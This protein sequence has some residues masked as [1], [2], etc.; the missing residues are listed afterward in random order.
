MNNVL[1]NLENYNK[2]DCI[3][4]EDTHECREDLEVRVSEQNDFSVLS[5]NIRSIKKNLDEFLIFYQDLNLA[6][7]VI[8][9][10]ESW[11][12]SNTT[13]VNFLK[14]VNYT[15]H[16]INP[17]SNKSDGLV[18]FV[19]EKLNFEVNIINL[20]RACCAKI[21]LS[22]NN[23]CYNIWAIYR[24]PAYDAMQFINELHVWLASAPDDNQIIIGDI[25]IDILEANMMSETY[26]NNLY[27]LGYTAAI[28]KPTRVTSSTST[29]IDHIFVKNANKKMLFSGIIPT[30]ITD[31]FTTLIICKSN[32]TSSTVTKNHFIEREFDEK[33]FHEI[34]K[35]TNWGNIYNEQDPEKAYLLFIEY[36]Q[37]AQDI[38]T[39]TSN[40]I[41]N[42]TNKKIKPWITTG[43]VKSIRSR[44]RLAKRVKTEPGNLE[45]KLHYKVYRN[46]LNKLIKNR[47]CEYYKNKIIDANDNIKSIWKYINEATGR[48]RK[49]GM[50]I[51]IRKNNILLTDPK[52]IAN[53]MNDYF[54][55]IGSELANK[56]NIN[57][58]NN[59]EAPRVNNTCFFNPTDVDEIKTIISSL[60][61]G[62]ST[63]HDKIS[64]EHIKLISDYI[65][66][67][68]CY[69]FNLVFETGK[70]PDNL[71]ISQITPIY[72][73]GDKTLCNNYRPISII[74]NFAKI[75]E[76]LLKKRL[77]SYL[78]KFNILD[79]AQFGFLENLGTE[80]AISR[81]LDDIYSNINNK[82]KVIG[83]FLDLRKAFDTVPHQRL[84][85]KLEKIGIRGKPHEI[86]TSYLHNRI[87]RTK[88]QNEISSNKIMTCGI[89]QGTVIGPVLFLIYLN[90]LLKIKIKKGTITSYADDTVAIFNGHNWEETI[91]S[92]KQGLL[93]ISRWLN[94]NTLTLNIDKT[95]ALPFLLPINHFDLLEKI[96]IN[97]Q[98]LKYNTSVKYLGITI[99]STLNWKEH[100]TTV[101][102]NIRKLYYIFRQLRTFLDLKLIKMLYYTFVQNI[103]QYGIIAWGSAYK[104]TIKKVEVAQRILIKICLSQPYD[105]P[106]NLI[107]CHFKVFSIKQLY[108]Q[109]ILLYMHKNIYRYNTIQYSNQYTRAINN[110][111]LEVP[112]MLT[113]LTQHTVTY[114]GPKIY[115]LLPKDIRS[116]KNPHK[117]K[118]DIKVWILQNNGYLRILN[119]V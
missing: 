91:A 47:K 113:K 96:K 20:N 103:V 59:E 104:T 60:K 19:K 7:D 63:G 106:T 67:P 22:K 69:I 112:R 62:K 8:I 32:D 29:C 93:D 41:I 38:A 86:F 11:V 3:C 110:Q 117:F 111:S 114:L 40:K 99:N 98:E 71:K 65:C 100:I 12:N 81:V 53:E 66:A 88:I 27:S 15:V 46:N 58:A 80:D 85:H 6:F 92:A 54:S 74:S 48:N 97:D 107:F 73:S 45:L 17:K 108:V 95:Y 51:N 116:I 31:H 39:R 84:L 55:N 56:L 50:V 36:I 61:T 14:I 82:Q 4:Y 79:K 23:I 52:E 24:S 118:K 94:C 43:L 78:S 89:P 64:T 37:N 2:I 109:K 72:K 102:N 115:N 83:V 44:D 77:C 49:N 68:L 76:K 87:Q 9:L 105:Y 101:T 28:N 35:S 21:I 42:S 1:Q 33:R 119:T 13:D 26:L 25:N 75:L 10:T 16:I 70:F 57:V 90:D 34:I 18:I 30:N 5:M